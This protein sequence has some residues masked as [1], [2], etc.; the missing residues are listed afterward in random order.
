LKGGAAV[1]GQEHPML[2][3]ALGFNQ[4]GGAHGGCQLQRGDRQMAIPVPP[5]CG[6]GEGFEAP[7]GN[8]LGELAL[9]IARGGRWPELGPERVMKRAWF[10]G[11]GGAASLHVV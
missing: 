9:A 3:L 5:P 10:G 4:D 8:H 6:S 11:G 7:Q 1:M 2:R